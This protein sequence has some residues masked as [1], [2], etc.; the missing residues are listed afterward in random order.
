MTEQRRTYTS[1]VI[2]R[3]IAAPRQVVWDALL[4]MIATATGGFVVEGEPAPH[5]LGAVFEF[6]M[7]GLSFREEV[8]SFEPP[9]RRVYELTGAPVAL[10]QGTTAI[11]DRG[12]SC[13]L[14]WS[15]VVDPLADGASDGFL[16]VAEAFLTGFVDRLQAMVE[17]GD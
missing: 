1:I 2:E 13:L 16:V 7:D 5:G 10:Y 15:I 3:E 12:D 8:I 6:G 14:A 4:D 11:T 9:W 17:S